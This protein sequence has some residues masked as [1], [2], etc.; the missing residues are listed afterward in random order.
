[1]RKIEIRKSKLENSKVA[2]K[3]AGIKASATTIRTEQATE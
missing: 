1:M 2:K 3:G